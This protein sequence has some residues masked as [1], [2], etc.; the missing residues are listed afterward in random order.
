[1]SLVSERMSSAVD[2]PQKHHIIILRSSIVPFRRVSLRCNPSHLSIAPISVLARSVRS[3]FRLQNN[4]IY[5]IDPPPY[6]AQST[7][8]VAADQSFH[9]RIP[10]SLTQTLY[11]SSTLSFLSSSFYT[12]P[13]LILVSSTNIST[14]RL[15]NNH[16]RFETLSSLLSLFFCSSCYEAKP[17]HA[18]YTPI[19]TLGYTHRSLAKRKHETKTHNDVLQVCLGLRPVGCP[20]LP[21]F[22]RG[23]LLLQTQ[24]PPRKCRVEGRRL[25]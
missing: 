15:L 19:A 17:R 7:Q 10:H 4:T 12:C 3:G 5:Y 6:P 9:T 16:L 20:C 13:I 21:Y 2:I 25:H 1:M 18:E 8:P 23:R 24:Q 11:F 14:H 22:L